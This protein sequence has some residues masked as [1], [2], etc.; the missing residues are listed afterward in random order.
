MEIFDS[1]PPV[2]R[3]PHTYQTAQNNVPELDL[4]GT[5]P[6]H[7]HEIIQTLISKPSTDIDGISVKLL[8]KIS[9]AISVPLAHIFNL[10]LENG[11][12]PEALKT[13]RTVPIFKG[14]DNL[15]MD[16]YRPISLISTFSKILE[17]MVALKL[18]NHLDI[19][20]SYTN[21]NMASKQKNPLN[22][23]SYTSQTKLVM[24]LTGG[25]IA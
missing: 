20:N 12:F 18:S 23:I 7:V 13:S 3:L 25:T 4:G 14:G 11:I 1:V 6:M 8:K 2:D 5:G 10:S 9:T 17:K 21:T 15:S 19:N 24:H 22:T 16:N